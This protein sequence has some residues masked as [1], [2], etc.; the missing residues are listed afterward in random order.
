MKWYDVEYKYYKE[1]KLESIGMVYEYLDKAGPTGINGKPCFFSLR[2]LNKDDT[3]KVF[4]YYEKYKEIREKVD[5][6]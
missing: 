3:K 5:N 1:V 4:D 6:F 2:L